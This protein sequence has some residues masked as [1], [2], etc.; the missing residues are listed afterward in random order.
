VSRPMASLCFSLRLNALCREACDPGWERSPCSAAVHFHVVQAQHHV[1]EGGFRVAQV[2]PR[3]VIVQVQDDSDGEAA[4]FHV[5]Q[6][7]P[8][9]VIVQVQDG[10][11]GEAVRSLGEAN[12]AHEMNW[13]GDHF[14]GRARSLCAGLQVATKLAGE[15][16]SQAGFRLDDQ[17]DD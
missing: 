4:H 7:Q 16:P 5:V 8:R 10:S 14:A 15:I 12:S 9:V 13:P 17:L 6:V 11:D 3:V 1:V 2:Q